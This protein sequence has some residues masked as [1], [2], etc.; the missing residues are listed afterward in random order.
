MM[1]VCLQHDNVCWWWKSSGHHIT[2]RLT[3]S[4]SIVHHVMGPILKTRGRHVHLGFLTGPRV[5]QCTRQALASP[6]FVFSLRQMNYDWVIIKKR[7]QIIKLRWRILWEGT[8]RLFYERDGSFQHY[9][10]DRYKMW[11]MH[12]LEAQSIRMYTKAFPCCFFV[13]QEQNRTIDKHFILGIQTEWQ[14]QKMLELGNK[15][16]IC[17]DDTFGTNNY[18]YPFTNF[19]VFDGHGNVLACCM[20]SSWKRDNGLLQFDSYRTQEHLNPE[21]QPPCF[22]FDE[23]IALRG[24]IQQIF[25]SVKILLCIWHAKRAWLKNLVAKVWEPQKRVHMIATP[26]RI[27]SLNPYT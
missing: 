8:S 18:K 24:V 16:A 11:K 26:S 19:G 9:S 15:Q 3:I 21:W 20:G 13:Y 14:T 27:L 1:P 5:W 23:C 12:E 7:D 4:L 25:P 6:M 17:I 10:N 2:T 22:I